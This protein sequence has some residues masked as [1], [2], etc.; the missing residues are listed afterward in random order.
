M[1][2]ISYQRAADIGSAI[3]AGSHPG[4]V[5]IGGGTN[6]LDLMKGGVA[7]PAKLVDITHIGGL[8]TITTLPDGGLRIGAL[9]RNSDA[10]NHTWVR[11]RY[12]LL[13]QAF[14]AGASAQL[15]NMATVGGNLMQRTR[16]YYFYDTAFPQ[17]NKRNPGSGCA[18]LEGN[19]RIHAILGASNQCIATNPSDMSVALAALDAVVRV[20][21]RD[22]ERA[23][24]FAEF[25]RLPGDRPDLDTT[26]KPGELITAVDLP[27]PLFADHSKYLKV[28]D[29]ASYAFA[30][31]SVAAALQMDGNTVKTARIALGGVAHKPWRANATEAA[32]IGKTLDR[33]TLQS[34]A[35]LAVQGAKPQRDNAFKVTLAQR[36]IV[37]AV[38]QAGGAA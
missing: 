23:I 12:P 31:V 21:G 30:L 2:A 14:L 17:C 32:L 27:P 37:R 25:H 29:R 10:A 36:A 1:D 9:V 19:T 33:A 11:E 20:S 5:Y 16:C 18:A 15:R 28:R 38:E 13:S 3:Q 8:D 6:L 4:T 7:R 35:A 26:L 22:G 34:A 24:P